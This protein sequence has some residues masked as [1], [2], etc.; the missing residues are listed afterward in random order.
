M[1]KILLTICM[2]FFFTVQALAAINI[3]TADQ[4]T[5][6]SING[7]GPAKAQAIIEYRNHEKFETVDDLMKVKGFG[8]KSME[9]IRN[10]ITVED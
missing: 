9:K 2:L 10:E 7:I 3:N 6:E 1:K 8:E 5:L 4:S